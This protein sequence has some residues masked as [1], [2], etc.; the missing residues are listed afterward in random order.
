MIVILNLRISSL[1]TPHLRSPLAT[2]PMPLKY[3]L[4]AG[5]TGS[6]MR[7][8]RGSRGEVATEGLVP[9]IARLHE[10][11]DHTKLGNIVDSYSGLLKFVI[12]C[13]FVD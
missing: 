11:S 8:Q 6:T 2:G 7:G 3:T 13:N 10:H 9:G 4:L 5:L 1:N 12:C